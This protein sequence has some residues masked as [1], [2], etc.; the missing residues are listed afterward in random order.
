MLRL[1]ILVV[2]LLSGCASQSPQTMGFR[3]TGVGNSVEDAKKDGFRKAI[4]Y[5]VGTVV[6][7][8]KQSI[9]N[10]LVKDEIISN[11]AGYVDDYVIEKQ[12]I[13]YNQVTLVMVV[14]VKSSS[15]ANRVLGKIEDTKNVNGDRMI[16]QYKTYMDNRKT[17]DELLNE[18]L[19]DWKKYAFTVKQRKYNDIQFVVDNQRNAVIVVPFEVTYNLHYLKAL[20][21]TLAQTQDRNSNLRQHSITIGAKDPDA[22]VLGTRDTFYFN[23]TKRYDMIIN[24]MLGSVAVRAKLI[25]TNGR[26]VFQGCNQKWWPVGPYGTENS[27]TI[28][29]TD[30]LNDDIEIRVATNG[31]APNLSQINSV[32]LTATLGTCN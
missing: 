13:N 4:E 24:Q 28:L 3:V 19:V 25:G 7:S 20:R 18:V 8:D 21:E 11:S 5:A 23:D 1:L 9:N 14:K 22:W 17:G 26:V 10:R 32:E 30:Q 31:S 12:T 15:I 29:G 6:L 27:I 2:A 16:T